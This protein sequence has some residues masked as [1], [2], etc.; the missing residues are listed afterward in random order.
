MSKK[1]SDQQLE[2]LLLEKKTLQDEI[3]QLKLEMK[4]KVS[5]D[6]VWL[7]LMT[8]FCRHLRPMQSNSNWSQ[9]ETL[10]CR[11]RREKLLTS[12]QN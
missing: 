2:S 6:Y 1:E 12:S 4:A 11:G 9:R 8:L 7:Q 3:A 5:L 10:S